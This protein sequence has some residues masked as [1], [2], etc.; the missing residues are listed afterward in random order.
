[1]LSLGF[2]GLVV[3]GAVRALNGLVAFLTVQATL[4]IS[5]NLT[6][7]NILHSN[8]FLLY[9]LT[10]SYSNTFECLLVVLTV[11]FSGRRMPGAAALSAVT[12]LMGRYTGVI[13]ALPS[14]LGSSLDLVSD[15][16]RRRPFSATRRGLFFSYYF[17]ELLPPTLASVAVCHALDCAL[18]KTPLWTP[19]PFWNNLVFNI[20][21]GKA[22]LYGRHWLGWY[23]VEALPAVLGTHI[24]GVLANIYFNWTIKRPRSRTLSSPK[25]SRPRVPSSPSSIISN[26]YGPMGV[27]FGCALYVT[28]LSTQAHKELRFLLP[29]LPFAMINSAEGWTA[30]VNAGKNGGRFTMAIK[31]LSA[32]LN[33]GVLLFLGLH[34][35]RLNTKSIESLAAFVNP[36][37]PSTV[38]LLTEC[39]WSPTNTH[40]PGYDVNFKILGCEP[41]CRAEGSCESDDWKE[42]GIM[43]VA[44]KYGNGYIWGGNVELPDFFLVRHHRDVDEWIKDKG[45]DRVWEE[46]EVRIWRSKAYEV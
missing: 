1:M 33:Y 41:E 45:Y 3:Q 16:L 31:W 38:H 29:V 39:H 36:T 35:Q 15:R 21:G 20:I 8:W 27:K 18:H 10:R 12:C 44:A 32:L 43:Y 30:L 7:W 17:R 6:L 19:P 5:P 22:E 14:L 4:R 42:G 28:L 46:G 26:H 2:R 11:Y 13:I 34:H 40:L 9:A 24:V 25:A 37:R 23:V